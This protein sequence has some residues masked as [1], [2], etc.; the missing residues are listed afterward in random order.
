MTRERNTQ[1][2]VEN[3]ED[4]ITP[5]PLTK[6]LPTGHYDVNLTAT[7]SSF[8]LAPRDANTTVSTAADDTVLYVGSGAVT[9]RPAGDAFNYI[10]VAEGSNYYRL[11][12]N[13]DADLLYLGIAGY[14]VSST[15]FDR[16]DPSTESKSRVTGTA[17]WLRLNLQEVQHTKP[18]GSTGN[19][20][21][22]LWQS[23][24]S[25]PRVFLS[26]FNDGTSNPDGNGLDTTD[27][28]SADDSVWIIA[29][30]HLALQLGLQRDRPI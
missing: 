12:Q 15:A 8:N 18:D 6:F 27:G 29:G 24:G 11:P 26:N 19:G 17:S 1:L 5:A 14:D 23:N 4:R 10:G 9:A 16:Y 13:Q 30:G 3:L 20:I 21:F 2:R 25:T 22:S 28:I 7:G